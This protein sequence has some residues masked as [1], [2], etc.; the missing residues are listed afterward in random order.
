MY[1]V[2]Y[3][4]TLSYLRGAKTEATGNYSRYNFGAAS[5]LFCSQKKFKFVCFHRKAMAK[6]GMTEEAL[7]PYKSF[8]HEV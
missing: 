7:V 4:C 5:F 2:D 8:T 3:V 6:C 1:V